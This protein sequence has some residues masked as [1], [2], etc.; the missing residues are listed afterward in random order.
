AGHSLGAADLDAPARGRAAWAV[1]SLLLAE[2]SAARW[3]DLA[4]SHSHL[5]SIALAEA[6]AE[7]RAALDRLRSVVGS[8]EAGVLQ[9]LRT[10]ARTFGAPHPDGCIIDLRLTHAAIAEMVG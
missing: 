9:S 7:A 2:I 5:T 3:A 8:A 4:A 6:R 10:L 1:T